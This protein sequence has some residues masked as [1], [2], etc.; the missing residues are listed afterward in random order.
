[1]AEA[2]RKRGGSV[3]VDGQR[4][5]E[6]P[7][8]AAGRARILEAAVRQLEVHGEASLRLASIAEEAGVAIALI[9]HHFGSRDRLVA[10]AQQVRLAG[11]VA[12]DVAAINAIHA[13]AGSAQ[14]FRQRLAAV[15]TALVTTDRAPTRLSR[16]AALAA[17]HGRP[18]ARAA[19]GDTIKELLDGLTEVIERGQQQGFIRDDLDPR[20]TATFV[21]A[22]AL[23]LVL[24]DLDP[25]RPDADELRHV[26]TVAIAG[27]FT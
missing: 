11:A 18:D 16:I 20:A 1:V 8:V 14:E 27:L 21:Q 9:T 7:E 2:W 24:A 19:L 6:A 10:A 25:D 5:G 13:E 3:V 22:Y 26:I 17:A 4:T 23:G 12:A 15:T